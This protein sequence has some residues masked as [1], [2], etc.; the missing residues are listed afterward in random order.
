MKCLYN[1]FGMPRNIREFAEDMRKNNLENVD[2]LLYR[3]INGY[4]DGIDLDADG[5]F[6]GVY[7][8]ISSLTSHYVKGNGP[9]ETEDKLKEGY[10]ELTDY[11]DIK[12]IKV[13]KLGTQGV[14]L[15]D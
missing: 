12:G 10:K 13:N 1:L 6:I 2:V 5:G 9:K 14:Q 8:E 7:S 15:D 4:E 3:Q 11:L